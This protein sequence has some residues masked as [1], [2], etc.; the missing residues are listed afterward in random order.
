MRKAVLFQ[1]RGRTEQ[2]SKG[3]SWEPG[4][5]WGQWSCKHTGGP[6]GRTVW[7]PK[8]KDPAVVMTVS[9]SSSGPFREGS[10]QGRAPEGTY[11]RSLGHPVMPLGKEGLRK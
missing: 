3:V 2:M 9:V 8:S 1:R 7:G 11:E 10:V 5:V 4:A 6:Q